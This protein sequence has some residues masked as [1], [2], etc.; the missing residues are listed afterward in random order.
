MGARVTQSW[1]EVCAELDDMGF[2]YEFEL[3]YLPAK[4]FRVDSGYSDRMKLYVKDADIL[5]DVNQK[6]ASYSQE[7]F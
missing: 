3:D 1:A 4:G 6:L 2:K 5:V 7:Y